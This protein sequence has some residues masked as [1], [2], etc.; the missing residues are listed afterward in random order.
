MFLWRDE[1]LKVS[2]DTLEAIL[3]TP[4]EY[5]IEKCDLIKEAVIFEETDIAVDFRVNVS[6]TDEVFQWI[7][8]FQTQSNTTYNKSYSDRNGA[9]KKTINRCHLH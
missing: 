3:P 7:E 8:S 5:L 6:S 2:Q 1:S 4:Y 9:G